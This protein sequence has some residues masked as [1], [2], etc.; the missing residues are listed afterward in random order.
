MILRLRAF[1][2]DRPISKRCE[3]MSSEKRKETS[4][5]N[6]DKK[7]PKRTAAAQRRREERSKPSEST[8][9]IEESIE[10][11]GGVSLYGDI[12]DYYSR[13]FG[14]FANEPEER[15]RR[16]KSSERES[17]PETKIKPASNLTR[18]QRKIRMVA[19]YI[20]VFIVI[21]VVA[22]TLSLTVMFRTTQITVESGKLPYTNEEIIKTSGLS[23]NENIFLSKKKAAQKKLVETYPYVEGAR[24]RI[25]IPGTQV[26]EIDAAVE[27]YQ[28]QLPGGFAV[29]SENSRILEVNKQQRSD[30]PLLK[31]LKL[32][33]TQPG[34]YITFEKESTKKI[35]DEVV[36]NINENEVGNIYGI[37]ISNTANIELNYDNRITILLGLPED[38]GYKLRTAKAIIGKSLSPADK[39]TLDVSLANSDRRSSYFTPIYSDAAS[40]PSA[41]SSPEQANVSPASE[42]DPQEDQTEY[43]DDIIEQEADE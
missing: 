41:S 15:P 24:V 3:K 8:P 37:D 10:N 22:V 7:P 40:A 35:L 31:G 9:S 14:N 29:V 11:F 42:E 38:V 36:K 13:T 30:I 39:G 17:V 5:K 33:E 1:E 34:E 4:K 12:D 21:V 26:I 43:L 23:Y 32:N 6:I 18:R 2:A 27:S 20:S 28:V 19:S 25:K 16:K